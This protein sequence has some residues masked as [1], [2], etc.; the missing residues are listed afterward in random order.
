MVQG[1]GRVE[2]VSGLENECDFNIVYDDREWD[3]RYVRN[4]ERIAPYPRFWGLQEEDLGKG[5]CSLPPG[6]KLTYYL[7]SI[8]VF[9]VIGTF[10]AE[11]AQTMRN[12]F[13]GVEVRMKRVNSAKS[14]LWI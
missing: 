6:K 13:V 2:G 9:E 10:L 8:P 5:K 3:V 1:Y 7:V 4:H 14:L 12:Y 11:Q